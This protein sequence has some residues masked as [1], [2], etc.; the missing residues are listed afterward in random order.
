[1]AMHHAYRCQLA[2]PACYSLPMSAAVATAD[3]QR[4]LL[5][6]QS[7]TIVKVSHATQARY[8]GPTQVQEDD[9]CVVEAACSPVV[10]S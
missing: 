5:D 10:C 7:Y 8:M 3:R 4:D 6:C 1:M 9:S 2:F